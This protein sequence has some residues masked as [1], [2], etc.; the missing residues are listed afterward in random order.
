MGQGTPAKNLKNLKT[1][2]ENDARI[3]R[4]Q[5]SRSSA[6]ARCL[7]EMVE[8]GQRQCRRR[9]WHRRR[10]RTLLLLLLLLRISGRSVPA[11]PAVAV[12]VVVSFHRTRCGDMVVGPQEQ[13]RGD[14]LEEVRVRF[15]SVSGSV[16]FD[17]VPF[18]SVE[19]QDLI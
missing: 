11:Q 4:W 5:T 7:V 12:V 2:L 15:G 1:V 9:W 17:W 16:R 8:G 3:R 19:Q 10:Q 14:R 18:C 6:R 13:A